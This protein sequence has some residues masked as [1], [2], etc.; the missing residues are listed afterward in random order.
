M[1]QR[2]EIHGFFLIAHTQLAVIVHPGVRSLY[3]P[4]TRTSFTFVAGLSHSLPRWH[5]RYIAPLPHL[6]FGGLT[7]VA[8]I[9]AEILGTALRRL[10]PRH[11]DRVQRLGQQLHVVPIGPGDDKRE[12]GA[13]AVHQQTALGPFFFPDLSGCFP[14]PLAPTEL[15]LGSRP[16][17]AIPSQF[18][19]SRRT[20]PTPL[21]TTVKRILPASTAESN[22]EWRWRYRNSW[23]EPSTGSRCGARR[24]WRR[25]LR[26]AKWVYAHRQA[27]VGTGVWAQ[28]ADRAAARVVP[29]VTRALW[30]LPRIEFSPWRDHGG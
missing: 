23:A 1:Q 3:H 10:R 28:C 26:A 6:F 20:L 27:A 2:L 5:M 25:K 4:A 17:F 13:T 12:R 16:S 8:L 9:H 24:R 22:C 7:D 18:P 29:R 14:P 30:R 15:C 19:P 21:A 11:H